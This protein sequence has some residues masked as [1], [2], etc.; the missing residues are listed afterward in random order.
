LAFALLWGLSATAHAAEPELEPATLSSIEQKTERDRDEILAKPEVRFCREPRR[1]LSA[2]ALRLCPLAAEVPDC[3]GFAK[4]CAE[5]KDQK[6]EAPGWL[7]RVAESLGGVVKVLVWVFLA[8]LMMLMLVPIVRGLVGLVRKR[9][10]GSTAKDIA[11]ASVDFAPDEIAPAEYTVHPAMELLARADRLLQSGQVQKALS[12]YL[13]A[14]L[15]GLADR[16]AL[17]LG[18]DRTNGEYV[19]ACGDEAARAELRAVVNTVDRV[20]FGAHEPSPADVSKVQ[21]LARKLAGVATMA[22]LAFGAMSCNEKSK[23]GLAASDPSGHEVLAE[24]LTRRGIKVLPLQTSLTQLPMLKPQEPDTQPRGRFLLID[25]RR[26]Q[27]SEEAWN[28]LERWVKSGGKLIVAGPPHELHA[29]F[30]MSEAPASDRLAQVRRPDVGEEDDEVE[31]PESGGPKDA[32]ETKELKEPTAGPELLPLRL[33]RGA[34]VQGGTEVAFLGDKQVYAA[35][36]AHGEG[37]V[38]VIA[39]SDPLSNIGLVPKGNAAAALRLVTYL[40]PVEITLAGPLDGLSLPDSPMAAL[41]HAGLMRGL[42]HALVFALLLFAYAGVRQARAT[43]A[44]S[45]AR[46]AFAEH[47]R[48]TGALYHKA[49]AG[50]HALRQYG[51]WV[52]EELHARRADRAALDAAKRIS[53]T[54]ADTPDDAE[55][56]IDELT[57]LLARVGPQARR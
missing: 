4:L 27:V 32:Q 52:L 30:H 41:S 9:R 10:R 15:R 46:R 17:A 21:G 5:T 37:M 39:S 28:H 11:E 8:A 43:P 29:G 53:A 2:E 24:L 23:Q 40:R 14:S 18:R 12:F 6:P 33:S 56:H 36:K 48:A 57:K 7:S 25:T 38:L 44:K 16:G 42:W 31:P 19:R 13:A 35:S 51:P 26:T 47:V 22:L 49:R 1:P 50:A 54:P 20:E 55:A 45:T 34:A 3:A